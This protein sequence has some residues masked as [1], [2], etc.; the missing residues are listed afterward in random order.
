[1]SNFVANM[2]NLILFAMIACMPA[3]LHAQQAIAYTY[4]AAGNRTG[5]GVYYS[6]TEMEGDVQSEE[7]AANGLERSLL[8][9]TAMPNP[10]RG[11][12]QVQVLD[13][14]EG[15]CCQLSLFSAA[16]SRVLSL[17]TSQVLTTL[18]LTALPD[19]IYL[20]R[21]EMGDDSQS[22]KIIKDNQ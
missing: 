10:T 8:R 11:Y 18:D 12:L 22:L 9:V 5:R 16:G 3:G 14:Q 19:G 15:G 4:D 7:N 17:S 2:R 20:L 21:A 1:M 13:L 6:L